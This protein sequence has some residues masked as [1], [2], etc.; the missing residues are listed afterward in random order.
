MYDKQRKHHSCSN[1]I[2]MALATASMD[3]TWMICITAAR[4]S[5]LPDT[6]D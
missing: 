6:I 1:A 4:L 3:P 2:L 5:K